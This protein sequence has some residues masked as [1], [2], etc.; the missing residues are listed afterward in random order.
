MMETVWDCRI[1][2][3]AGIPK[4]KQEN[5]IFKIDVSINQSQ[6]KLGS[7]QLPCTVSVPDP[8]VKSVSP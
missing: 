2:S 7:I 8:L 1:V 6:A 4:N 3:N 5:M